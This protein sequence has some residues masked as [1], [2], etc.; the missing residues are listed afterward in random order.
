MVAEC[1]PGEEAVRSTRSLCSQIS[2]RETRNVKL[3]GLSLQWK[4]YT[5]CL[6]PE[7]WG[8]GGS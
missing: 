4:R 8:N 3:S 6:L 5:T 1:E 7:R 2:A